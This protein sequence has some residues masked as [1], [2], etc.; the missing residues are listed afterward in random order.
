MIS[1]RAVSFDPFSSSIERMACLVYCAE[2][3]STS[4]L[5]WRW[6]GL[7]DWRDLDAASSS[8]EGILI[9]DANNRLDE[10]G[11]SFD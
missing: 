4:R 9:D 3:Y 5:L 2:R 11:L 1:V 8:T 7:C 6:S 10:G